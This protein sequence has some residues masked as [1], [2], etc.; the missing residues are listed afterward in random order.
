VTGIAG[1]GGGSDE[2]PVGTVWVGIAVKGKPAY[3]LK[4]FYPNDRPTFKLMAS[5]RALDILRRELLPL[6]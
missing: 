1:P 5:Q 2:K 6:V 4:S 3:A